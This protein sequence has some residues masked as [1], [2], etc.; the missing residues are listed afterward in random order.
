MRVTWP[1]T[2]TR[3]V[4]SCLPGYTGNPMTPGDRC[5]PGTGPIPTP[6]P[7]QPGKFTSCAPE[8]L[9]EI[10]TF[11]LKCYI[12]RTMSSSQINI[13]YHSFMM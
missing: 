8:N 5:T 4:C 3:N 7:P 6:R 12:L 1:G 10:Y 11:I 9:I 2:D 13:K